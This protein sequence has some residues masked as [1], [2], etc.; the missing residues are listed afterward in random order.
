MNLWGFCSLLTS[1]QSDLNI[2]HRDFL[3]GLV[4]IVPGYISRGP[5][6]IPGATRFAEKWRHVP[7][8]RRL[9]INPHVAS[10]QKTTFFISIFLLINLRRCENLG[11]IATTGRMR[12]DVERSWKESMV[13]KSRNYP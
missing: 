10:S 3:C 12:D 2:V 6:S 9:I 4:V 1:S 11:D 7:P 13:A 5:V 8:R